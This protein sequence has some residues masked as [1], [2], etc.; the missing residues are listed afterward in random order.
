[1]TTRD[2]LNRAADPNRRIDE[3]EATVAS[4]KEGVESANRL[5]Q[6]FA[7]DRDAA[8][9]RVGVLE[10]AL[11]DAVD[12]AIWMSG[13]TDFSPGGIAHEGWEKARPKLHAAMRA[14]SSPPPHDGE[15]DH[16]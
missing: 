9:A 16:G 8:L 11:G 10:A 4:W 3:L 14:L 2:S 15:G 6:R 5:S 1:M 7:A 13:S 12:V